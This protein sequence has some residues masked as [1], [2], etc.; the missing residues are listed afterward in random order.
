MKGK[1]YCDGCDGLFAVESL[2]LGGFVGP[3]GAVE[4]TDA[5]CASCLDALQAEAEAEAFWGSEYDDYLSAIAEDA[6]V[7]A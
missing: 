6:A 4:V 5:H 2:T 1:I 7:T 3:D